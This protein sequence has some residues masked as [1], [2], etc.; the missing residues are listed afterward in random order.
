MTDFTMHSHQPIS[1]AHV[2]SLA[3]EWVD[4]TLAPDVRSRIEAHLDD[5]ESCANLVA[6]LAAIASEAHAL[7]RLEPSRDLWAGIAARIETPVTVLEPRRVVAVSSS[8]WWKS[9]VAAAALVAVTAGVTW[10]LATRSVRDEVASTAAP[11]PAASSD[12]T[13][14]GSA[15]MPTGTTAPDSGPATLQEQPAQAAQPTTRVAAGTPRAA[16]GA[17]PAVGTGGRRPALAAAPAVVPVAAP[18]S[19]AAQAYDREIAGMR[20]LVTERRK[21]LDPTTVRVLERN[22]EII[23]QAIAES[24]AALVQDP[25]SGLLAEQLTR[26]M[27]RKLELLRSAADLPARIS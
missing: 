10:H 11:A 1:C 7:P 16:S 4:G 24:R 6:D 19:A 14:T 18:L 26:A 22:L 23:D 12:A 21:D 5:C 17:R 2:E 9:A 27:K 8:R 15:P 20:A 13:G 25:A 3:S